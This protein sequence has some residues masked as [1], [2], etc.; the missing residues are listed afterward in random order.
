I[1]TYLPM[2][3]NRN[4]NFPISLSRQK[5]DFGIIAA[6]I[7]IIAALAA[8]A[9]ATGI[10]ISTSVQTDNI[11]N[12]LN[13]LTAQALDTQ[14]QI[15]AHLRLAILNLNQQTFLLQE[16]VDLLWN[17]QGVSCLPPFNSICVTPWKVKNASEAVKTLNNYIKEGWSPA[18]DNYTRNL[19]HTIRV[20]NETKVPTIT[21]DTFLQ[22]LTSFWSLI[23]SWGGTVAMFLLISLIS[24]A[25]LR[26]LW[27]RVV[28]TRKHQI[29][30]AQALHNPTNKV[31]VSLIH[32]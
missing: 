30:L 2:P 19:L 28:T 3:V 31:W 5:R 7:A 16:Q 6:A 27:K 11:L 12:N 17:L 15:N 1:P 8:S 13:A 26:V 9:V 10:A 4:S 32:H 21:G 22:S 18:F 24:L 14:Q 29:L 23:R 25:F 20:I